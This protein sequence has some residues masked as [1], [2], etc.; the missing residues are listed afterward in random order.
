VSEPDIFINCHQLTT[1]EALTVRVALSTLAD[2]LV[3]GLG[4]DQMGKDICAGYQACLH[5]LFKYIGEGQ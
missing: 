3:D 1:A 5:N 4:D 2:A